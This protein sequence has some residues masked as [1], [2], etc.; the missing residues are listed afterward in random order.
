MIESILLGT[1]LTNWAVLAHCCL[2]EETSRVSF[3]QTNSTKGVTAPPTKD[4]KPATAEQLGVSLRQVSA[5]ASFPEPAPSTP[6]DPPAC[7]VPG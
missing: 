7:C 6:P 3:M 2:Q 5:T 4:A 1:L